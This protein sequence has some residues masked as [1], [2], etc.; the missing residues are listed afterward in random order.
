MPLVSIVVET[1]AV[2]K[3]FGDVHALL[4]TDFTLGQGEIVALLGP[5]GAGKTTLIS[6]LLG[7]RKP[8]AGKVALFGL[9]PRDRRARTRCGVMLQESGVPEFLRV[10]EIVDQFR[11]YY[12]SPLERAA[13]VEMSGLEDK[14]DALIH[15]LS[16]GQRQ[17]L[18]FAL[19]IC[20]DPEALFLDEPTVGMDVEARRNFWVRLRDSAASGRTV[21]LT[22]H[23][24][25][26][27]DAIASR[28]VVIDKGRIIADA[29]PRVLKSRVETKRVSFDSSQPLVDADVAGLP[30]R[31]MAAADGRVSIFTAEPQSVL[32]ALFQR[33]FELRNLEVVGASLEDAVVGLTAEGRD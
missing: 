12:P 2:A 21:L 6:L 16:G 15:T 27:A 7:L 5:N 13:V 33:G 18:Y 31:R 30:I 32:R 14:S 24:L 26:E 28:V 23:Y 3:N 20:G 1:R 19:A 17:R 9:D 25:D 8:T 29:P 22:T 10:R 11:S 4:A